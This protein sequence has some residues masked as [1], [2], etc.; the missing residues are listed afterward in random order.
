MMKVVIQ[1]RI[2]GT[3]DFD[4]NW[5]EY[6]DGFGD[7]QK[8]YWLGNK[9]LNI[10]TTNGKYELRVDLTDT[11]NK[12]TYALYKTF[13][14]SDENSQYKLTIGGHSGTAS[15]GMAYNNGMKFST[16]ER[17]YDTR[18]SVNCAKSD[19]AWWHGSCSN[20]SN[21]AKDL[22]NA[23]FVR[24]DYNKQ[25]RPIL[26]QTDA[27]LVTVSLQL[28]SIHEIDEVAEKLVVAGFLDIF[29]IDEHL[30]WDSAD[31]NDI[32]SIAILQDNI[33][34]PNLALKNGFKKLE[35]LGGSFY[36]VRIDSNGWV[37]WLPYH[38]FESRCSIDVTHFPFD[39]QSCQ[40]RFTTW[41]YYD[42]EVDFDLNSKI[43]LREYTENSLW[44]ITSTS[45]Q[46]EVSLGSSEVIFTI[47]LRRKATYYIINI[48]LPI[49]FL[50]FLNFLV[51][52]VPVDAGEKMSYSVSVFLSFVVF[53][54]MISEQL[55]VNSESTSYLSIFIVIQLGYSILVLVV[56][57][58]Q[59]RIHH[60]EECHRKSKMYVNI[61]KLKRRI[62][63]S[64]RI[65][66]GSDSQDREHV[67]INGE[68]VGENTSVKM[69]PTE[70]A[71]QW[72]DVSYAVDFF[73]FWILLDLAID[74]HF[75]FDNAIQRDDNLKTA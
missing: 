21:D 40:V 17:D 55:P 53:L 19:G 61:V 41:T 51:F 56:N 66:N 11:N 8:E 58:L 12:M 48:V 14:V 15:N 28:T 10:I 39:K 59:L 57:S 64:F 13:S 52:I 71:L 20:T 50:G 18:S 24:S 35:E 37:T 73:A 9:F 2:D 1:R 38:V 25:V 72:R 65:S 43:Q 30:V 36:N 49:I 70:G 27:V 4:R 47:N 74:D 46:L 26:D 5:V 63:Y 67:N 3:T 60:R 75:C 7:P 6:R 45:V 44:A 23:L 68:S 29:W 32:D 69:N 31:Y 34:K 22:Y 42:F 54:T 62:R 16:K 33:W